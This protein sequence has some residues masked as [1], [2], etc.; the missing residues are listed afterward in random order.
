MEAT[1]PVAQQQLWWT[2]TNRIVELWNKLKQVIPVEFDPR[3]NGFFDHDVC[4]IFFPFH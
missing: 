3:W 1:H 2:E 4:N